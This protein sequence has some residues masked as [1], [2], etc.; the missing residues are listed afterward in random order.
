MRK[1]ATEK[2]APTRQPGGSAQAAQ[3]INPPASGRQPTAASS[4]P[5]GFAPQR[6][7]GSAKTATAGKGKEVELWFDHPNAQAVFVAGTFNHWQPNATP[8]KHESGDKWVAHLDLKPGTYEYRFVADGQWYDD[9]AAAQHRTNP[10]GGS[11]SVLTVATTRQ[12]K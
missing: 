1:S 12:A 10:F 5:P 8:L 9:P 3:S 4:P 7:Q 6:T 11:N 2:K